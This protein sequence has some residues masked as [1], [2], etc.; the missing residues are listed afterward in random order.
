MKPNSARRSSATPDIDALLQDSYLLV[1]ALREGKTPQGGRALWRHCSE[2][3]ETLR[4]ALEDAGMNQR[5]IDCISYAQCALLD[6]TVLGCTRDDDH[7]DWASNP[8]QV[9]FFNRHQAGHFLYEDM[10]EAL[11]DP[12]AATEV[13]TVYQRVLLLGFKGR[14]RDLQD[15]EREALIRALAAR[16]EPLVMRDTLVSGTPGG[17]AAAALHWL[18]SPPVQVVVAVLLVGGTWWALDQVLGGLVAAL[19]PVPT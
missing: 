14:Y 16:T 10:R 11:R 6:E 8:L 12:A 13:L 7:A 3:V 2:Q 5:S 15:P 1:V 17:R 4:Q 9:K 18:R 19:L